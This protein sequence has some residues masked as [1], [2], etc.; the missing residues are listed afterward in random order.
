MERKKKTGYEIALERIEEAKRTRATA[1][2]LGGLWLD[3]IPSEIGELVKLTHLNLSENQL[4]TLP[5]E[6]G[7]LTNLSVLFLYNN[8][9]AIL[10]KV[11]GKLRLLKKLYLA[12]NELTALTPE[13]R[14]LAH[15]ALLDLHYNQLT[16]FPFEVTKLT[17]LT[18]LS[19]SGNHFM[20]LPSE[21]G[22]LVK[23]EVL[24][25]RHNEL[26]LLPREIGKL[27]NLTQIDLK[28]NHLKEPPQVIVSKGIK[29][30]RQYFEEYPHTNQ[31]TMFQPKA[32]IS[33]VHENAEQISCLRRELEAHRIAVW[34]DIDGILPGERWE[35]KIRSAIR[36]GEFF[37]ACFSN[38]YYEKDTN[39][40]DKELTIAAEEIKKRPEN[41]SWFIP[42]LLSDCK[43]PKRNIGGGKTLRDI[44]WVSLF[45]DWEKGIVRILEVINI[46]KHNYDYWESRNLAL[47]PPE[48]WKEIERLKMC[49]MIIRKRIQTSATHGF[50]IEK[51]RSTRDHLWGLS[52]ICDTDYIDAIIYLSERDISLDIVVTPE[53]A[54]R[55]LELLS[56]RNYLHI[57][58]K[59]TVV[60]S[61]CPAIDS[62]G[63]ALSESFMSLCLASRADPNSFDDKLLF[64]DDADALLWG[65]KLF[66]F[67]RSKATVLTGVDDL[68]KFLPLPPP[69]RR[70]TLAM[71][72]V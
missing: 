66:R 46:P 39:Y 50:F 8:K 4:T 36:E 61:V 68:Q 7:N 32:F 58:Q 64:G 13:I 20:S 56:L 49:Q 57:L 11:I 1:L 2:S 45:K 18:L 44:Q 22:E 30:I 37:F 12:D 5:S 38:E 35:D 16:V 59:E 28:G 51:L 31:S 41:Q 6:I 62:G 40:M 10:P 48:L 55:A 52:P 14:N 25:L 60:L 27:S 69:P 9:L 33:Y 53:V 63:I 71:D 67:Y 24:D 70:L 43:V 21:I 42:V 3:E 23:L 72:M 19:L 47:I 26:T 15:L 54:K 17:N 65:E 34:Q 29:A